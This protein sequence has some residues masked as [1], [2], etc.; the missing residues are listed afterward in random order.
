MDLVEDEEEWEEDLVDV[1]LAVDEVAA[2]DLAVEVVEDQEAVEVLVLEMDHREA[3][4][5]VECVDHQ[6]VVVAEDL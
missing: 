5:A 2:V 4:T 1:H 6:W 3:E